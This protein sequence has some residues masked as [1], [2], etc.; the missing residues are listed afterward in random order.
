MLR[1]R[2]GSIPIDVHFSHF[3]MS[4]LIAWLTADWLQFGGWPGEAVR[5]PADAEAKLTY[6]GVVALWMLIVFVSVLVHELG[7]ALVAKTFGYRPSIQLVGLGGLTNPNANET[8]PWHRDV[9]LTLAGP[10]SGLALGLTAG[11]LKLLV[12]SVGPVAFLLSALFVANLFWAAVNLLPVSTLDGGRIAS[13]VLVHLFGRRGFLF[14]QLISVVLGGAMV[15]LGL[16]TGAFFL[17][18]IFGLNVVRA[19]A[20][21]SGYWR[22][23]L[24]PQGPSHPFELA[25]LQAQQQFGEGKLELAGP[26]LKALGEEELQPQLRARVHDLAGWVAV[27]LGE[28][29]AALDHFSQVQGLTVAPQALAAAFSLIGDDA[30]A[31]PLWDQAARES[32]DPTLLHEWAGALIRNDQVEKAR[33]HP[34]VKLALAYAAA[35][36]TWFVRKDYLHAAEASLASF[37]EEKNP[38]RAYD[39]GCAFALAGRP[40]DALRMLE[41][42]GAS[43]AL[44]ADTAEW[45][46]ELVCLRADPRFTD[47]LQR[48]RKVRR[49]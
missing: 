39:A 5:H 20:Q 29:R 30:R 12:T 43:G 4:G 24:P 42:A 48:L 18:I 35:A 15:A 33:S 41:E 11:A 46:P 9:L 22:G 13:A 6:A 27:K 26:L 10:L 1:F 8:I 49:A 3:A 31:I 19:V 17:A 28:G 25:F 38:A 44:R 2:L 37:R 32:N 14:A 7:H 40:D 16:S 36:R 45:D 23:E 34:A 21:I 47:W